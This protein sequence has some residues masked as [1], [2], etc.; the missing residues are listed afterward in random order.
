MPRSWYDYHAN[1]LP[2]DAT[3][4]QIA[5]REFN[6]RILAGR[7]PYFMQYIYPALR[8][9]YKTY[10]QSVET[11]C[12][13]EFRITL[14]EI[15]SIPDD[16]LTEDQERFISYYRKRLPVGDNDCVMNRICRKFEALFDGK[17]KQWTDEP[18][19]YTIMKS[20]AEYTPGQYSQVRKV[21]NRHGEWVQEMCA[22]SR[23]ER[24]TP[25]DQSDGKLWRAWFK[26]QRFDICNNGY[27]ICDIVLDMCYRKSSSKEF[28]WD[29]GGN[30]IIANLVKRHGG[31]IMY[32]AKDPDGDIEYAGMRFSMR[33]AQ[34]KWEEQEEE[35]IEGNH[36]EREGMGEGS[37]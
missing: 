16:Q 28:A 26:R 14:A 18:F 36:T 21:Y 27:V 23:R 3:D 34:W 8:K 4:E 25:S 19:D 22:R 32:P 15:L 20:G 33:T 13:R 12:I 2:D 5:E 31:E 9:D 10:M 24:V 7:K 1:A 17:M 37:D 29:I 35:F 11:K 6:L 30:Y